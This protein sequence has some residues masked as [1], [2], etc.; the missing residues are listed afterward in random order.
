VCKVVND[1]YGWF[2]SGGSTPVFD[3]IVIALSS[4]NK[5][6]SIDEISGVNFFVVT[7]IL[8]GL[9]DVYE[10]M[11]YLCYMKSC[12]S[13]FLCL[14]LYLTSCNINLDKIHNATTWSGQAF[15]GFCLPKHMQ[16]VNSVQSF[17]S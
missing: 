13:V 7:A 4:M 12:Y 1:I 8:K 10:T 14:C 6:L 5:V 17:N 15:S 16:H 11:K 2:P 9:C 3:E